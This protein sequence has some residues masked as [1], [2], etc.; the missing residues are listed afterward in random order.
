M[1]TN[2]VKLIIKNSKIIMKRERTYGGGSKLCVS[3]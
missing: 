3:L 1:K 2:S